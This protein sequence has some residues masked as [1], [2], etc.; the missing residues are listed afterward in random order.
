M[1][2]GCPGILT[3]MTVV[4][5]S[6]RLQWKSSVKALKCSNQCRSLVSVVCPEEMWLL[7]KA[8]WAVV[9]WFLRRTAAQASALAGRGASDPRRRVVEARSFAAANYSA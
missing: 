6:G 7:W 2:A 3:F 5:Y 1:R 8:D 9:K 4:R